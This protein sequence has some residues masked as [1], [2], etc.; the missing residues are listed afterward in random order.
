M[1]INFAV[2]T[3][4]SNKIES[5]HELENKNYL[6]ERDFLYK[7]PDKLRFEVYNKTRLA[8]RG[9]RE[10]YNDLVKKIGGEVTQLLY[11]RFTISPQ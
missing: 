11:R 8:V 10:L 6:R 3:Y 9:D 4:F 2:D 7:M 1:N 5:I